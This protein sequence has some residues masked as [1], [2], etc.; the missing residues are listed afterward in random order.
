MEF[1]LRNA[2]LVDAGMDRTQE[3]ITIA[4]T[5]IAGVGLNANVQRNV[6]DASNTIITPS[7]VEVHTHGGGGFNLHTGTVRSGI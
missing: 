6:I 4:G 5:S 3:N 7:F 1:T 2:R